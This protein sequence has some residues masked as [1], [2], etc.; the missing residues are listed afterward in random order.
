MRKSSFKRPKTVLIFNGARILIAVV[1]S[2]HSAAELTGGNLQAISFCCTGK[3]VCSGGFYFRHLHP[4]VEIDVEDLDT[5][6]LQ[7]YDGLCG[8]KRTY[9][10]V[11]KMARKRALIENRKFNES[12]KG[13]KDDQGE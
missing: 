2:L 6:Q 5:L 3:Y 13:G 4:E 11:R 10:S 8:E 7:N 1:R 12:K 9:H